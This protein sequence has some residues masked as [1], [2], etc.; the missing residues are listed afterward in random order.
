MGRLSYIVGALTSLACACTLKLAA[1]SSSWTLWSFRLSIS[2][3]STL[4]F[5]TASSLSASTWKEKVRKVTLDREF[6]YSLPARPSLLFS[7][8]SPP[9]QTHSLL[10][11]DFSFLLG[12]YILI[13]PPP[14]PPPIWSQ[15][16]P[17]PGVNPPSDYGV[18]LPPPP[19]RQI[20]ESI[21]PPPP[22]PLQIMDRV[23]LSPPPLRLW[24]ESISPPPLRLWIESISLRLWS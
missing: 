24:I 9:L 16:I 19:P 11:M 4:T 1:L 10:F 2:D 7:P 14:P 21:P 15:I 8:S 18:N 3:V 22:P 17:L 5:W 23:N 13:P 12:S 6:Y 20:M